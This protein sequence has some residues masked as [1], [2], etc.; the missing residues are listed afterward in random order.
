MYFLQRIFATK[1]QYIAFYQY[2]AFY[3]IAIYTYLHCVL[4]STNF[5]YV[6]SVHQYTAFYQYVA[7]YIIAISFY[8]VIMAYFV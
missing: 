4:S 6:V 2:V 7:F 1:C 5:C 8:A 3:I